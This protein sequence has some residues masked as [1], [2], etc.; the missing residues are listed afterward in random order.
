MR[1]SPRAL[2]RAAVLG[3]ALRDSIGRARL[4]GRPERPGKLLVLHELLLG[5]TLMLAAL[6][7]ALRSRYPEADIYVTAKPAY[8]PLFN[9]SPYGARVL[10]FTER[11]SGALGHL[12]PAR[13]A[14]IAFL[15]GENRHAWLAR[16]L[17]ARWIVGLAG[18]RSKFVNRLVDERVPLPDRPTALA[19]IFASLSGHRGELRYRAGDWPAPGG[20]PFELPE[21]PYAVLHPGAGS[22]LRYWDVGNWRRLADALHERRQNVVWSAGPGEEDRIR[23]VDPDARFRSYA[24]KLDT[25]Q[26][27]RL[28][29]GAN[30]LVSV[31]TGVA[32]VGKLTG[33]RTVC[34]YGPGSST[35]FGKGDFWR[36]APFF[37]VTVPDFPCRDQRVLFK[38]EIA[39]VRRCARTLDECPRPRCMEA[40]S[41]EQVLRAIG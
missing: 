9:G 5:D 35:L 30:L 2:N 17:G 21:A 23:Q 3:A 22:P 38:R 6:L 34:L 26:L 16:A 33:T 13:G 4:P 37:E 7:A 40:I 28:V 24:G 8:A 1:A 18:G 15:P 36:D 31:D 39:W 20:T 27:W 10:P 32:H 14:D 12:R 41:V 29:A 25:A 11:K 19:E